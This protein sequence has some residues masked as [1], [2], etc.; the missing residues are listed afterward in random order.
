MK[1]HTT[2]LNKPHPSGK[3][4]TILGQYKDVRIVYENRPPPETMSPDDQLP[5][6]T[7]KERK[8]FVDNIVARV[9]WHFRKRSRKMGDR[10]SRVARALLTGRH[11]SKLHIPQRSFLYIRKK[12]EIFFEALKMRSKSTSKRVGR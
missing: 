7:L 5:L 3:H 10:Y 12:V 6:M 11:W 1:T 2:G 9:R 4:R 8:Q